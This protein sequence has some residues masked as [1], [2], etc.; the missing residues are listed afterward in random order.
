MQRIIDA[1]N[2]IHGMNAAYGLSNELVETCLDRIRS[3]KV[4]TPVIGKFSSGKSAAIN[5]VLGYS[6]KLLKED[7]T[8]ETAVPTEIL[9]DSGEDSFVLFD[10]DGSS[11][12]IERTVFSGLISNL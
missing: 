7:M 1:L 10:N 5:T 3:A 4:C 12:E 2:S 9:Y 11:R 6:K 8:P